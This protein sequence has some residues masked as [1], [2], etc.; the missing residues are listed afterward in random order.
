MSKSPEALPSNERFGSAEWCLANPE[1]AHFE[2][3]RLR[4]ALKQ[5]EMQAGGLPNHKA[6]YMASIARDAL[7]P[8]ETS[9]GEK[10][11]S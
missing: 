8:D 7:Q 11:S 6:A 5:I 3:E 10:E 4:A 9:C 2:I 1:A